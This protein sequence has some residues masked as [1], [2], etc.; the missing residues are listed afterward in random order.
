MGILF[1]VAIKD[2]VACYFS[3]ESQYKPFGTSLFC[4]ESGGH[5]AFEDQDP[6]M[7]VLKAMESSD[8]VAGNM[9]L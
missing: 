6:V 8:D 9:E 1:P 7:A 2:R 5:T 3:S 4:T